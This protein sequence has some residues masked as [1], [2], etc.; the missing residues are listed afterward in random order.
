[1]TTL[2]KARKA[3]QKLSFICKKYDL[4]DLI[5]KELYDA[6]DKNSIKITRD[7]ISRKKAKEAFKEFDECGAIQCDYEAILDDVPSFESELDK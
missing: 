3:K 5:K 7:L 6:L 4:P 1:M 2:I